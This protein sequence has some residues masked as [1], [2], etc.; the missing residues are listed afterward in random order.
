MSK[1]FFE[2]CLEALKNILK[3]GAKES[4][5]PFLPIMENCNLPDILELLD[6]NTS[7]AI[8]KL[9]R[10]ILHDFFG[11]EGHQIREVNLSPEIEKVSFDSEDNE[12][13]EPGTTTN[14][15]KKVAS[16]VPEAQDSKSDFI[17]AE[18]E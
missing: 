9:H 4:S 12:V 11:G 10:S 6:K 5:N 3:A 8:R 1:F 15:T 2:L 17:P 13:E 14:P 16:S 7:R 18:A